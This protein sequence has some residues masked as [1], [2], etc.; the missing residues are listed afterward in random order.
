MW[1][2]TQRLKSQWA[3]LRSS[4]HMGRIK[5]LDDVATVAVAG[6]VHGRKLPSLCGKWA[7]SQTLRG[8]LCRDYVARTVGLTDAAA[9]AEITPAIDSL[10]LP[11]LERSALLVLAPLFLFHVVSSREDCSLFSAY[12]NVSHPNSPVALLPIGA[13]G[14]G[15]V[16]VVECIEK[17]RLLLEL[18]GF[19]SKPLRSSDPLPSSRRVCPSMVE[20]DEDAWCL[21]AG[22]CRLIRHCDEPNAEAGC[23]AVGTRW[24]Y[25]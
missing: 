18:P 11:E 3:E 9:S 23:T 19:L 17:H 7:E 15:M 16:A 22:P 20:I 6:T 25:Q 5:L 12:R 14:V 2:P 13:R 21:L 24:T 10:Q 4:L 1:K 8:T